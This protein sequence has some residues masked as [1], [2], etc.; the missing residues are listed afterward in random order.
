M[1]F[2]VAGSQDQK[3]KDQLFVSDFELEARISGKLFV[4]VRNSPTRQIIR[5]QFNA[6]SITGQNAYKVFSHL[7][8]NLCQNHVL[9]SFELHFEE[10]VRQF[11]YDDTLS[12][13]KIF[14]G[15]AYLSC[16]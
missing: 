7:T 3:S 16:C 13:N 8:G 11:V 5:G 1:Q 15:Q 6:D 10:G 9:G 4:S 14:F 12:R 2:G